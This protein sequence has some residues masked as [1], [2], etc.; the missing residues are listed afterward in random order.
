MDLPVS[1]AFHTPFMAPAAEKFGEALGGFLFRAPKVPVYAN[2]TGDLYPDDPA[3]YAGILSAQIR[4]P[5][6]WV[7]EIEAMIAAGADTFV[8]CGPGKTLSGLIR[9]IDKNVTVL[10]AENEETLLST[11][12][13]L[14]G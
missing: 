2:L 13:A 3:E 14:K 12:A 6:R 8:E 10:Q 9:K 7:K 1:G 4:N 11:V 5:V